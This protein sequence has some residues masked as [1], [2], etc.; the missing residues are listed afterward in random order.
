M[1]F[2]RIDGITSSVL[3]IENDPLMLTAIG[4]VLNMRGHRA[5]LARTEEVALEAIRHG[6]FDVIVISIDELEAGCRSASRIRGLT[7]TQD[8]P[9]IFL[10][11]P[12]DGNWDATLS[13]QGG[14]FSM[15]KPGDPLALIELVEKS[16][17]LPHIAKGRVAGPNVLQGRQG[18]W[19]K[20][21]ER[22]DD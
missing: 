6:I 16:L 11:P 18:D 10:V 13:A 7:G 17:W 5:V 21:D 14:V 22:L 12:H 1:T 8:V 4:S 3:V 19:I 20:L 2:S 9:L 15:I